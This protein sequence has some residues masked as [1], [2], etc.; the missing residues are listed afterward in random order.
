[1]QAQD[2][3]P[4]EL[5]TKILQDL[6]SFELSRAQNVC[7]LFWTIVQSRVE[8]GHVKSDLFIAKRQFSELGPIYDAAADDSS[9]KFIC[10]QE[11]KINLKIFPKNVWLLGVGF[12]GPYN[13]ENEKSF[14]N[15]H[16]CVQVQERGQILVSRHKICKVKFPEVIQPIFFDKPLKLELDLSYEISMK[17]EP[18]QQIDENFYE[19][20]FA[21][22]KKDFISCASTTL[23]FGQPF[24]L[25]HCAYVRAGQIRH[26]YLWPGEI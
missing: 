18:Q 25:F 19:Y 12:H 1:M 5:W 2:L 4:V 3:L 9:S 8:K 20:F 6:T 10:F 7:L 26:L 14:K 15:L 24:Y 17:F 13:D 23:E 22:P 21:Y 16:I 11:D